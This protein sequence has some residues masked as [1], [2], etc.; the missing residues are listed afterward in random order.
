MDLRLHP[1]YPHPARPCGRLRGSD[2]AIGPVRGQ[3][4]PPFHTSEHLQI[5]V[6]HAFT[7]AREQRP[8]KADLSAGQE[9]LGP[10]PLRCDAA[11]QILKGWFYKRLAFRQKETTAASLQLVPPNT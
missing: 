5:D 11:T 8:S 7:Y 1:G 2:L 3:A 6:T 4:P 10:T 9:N